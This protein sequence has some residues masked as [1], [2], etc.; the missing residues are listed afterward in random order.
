MSSPCQGCGS[1]KGA[2]C[3]SPPRQEPMRTWW[4]LPAAHHNPACLESRRCARQDVESRQAGVHG[5]YGRACTTAPGPPQV[6]PTPVLAPAVATAAASSA[7]TGIAVLLLVRVRPQQ[8]D[9]GV[10]AFHLDAA[11][12][13]QAGGDVLPVHMSGG[14]VGGR[15]MLHAAGAMSAVPG[16]TPIHPSSHSTKVA[17]A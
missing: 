3:P 14:R 17:K 8:G 13:S 5:L 12:G 11:G 7:T 6:L 4:G 2:G 10:E 15:T 9:R 1:G 16:N